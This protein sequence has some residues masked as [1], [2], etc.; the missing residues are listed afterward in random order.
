[1]VSKTYNTLGSSQ[2]QPWHS[3]EIVETPEGK[4]VVFHS[5]IHV[6]KSTKLSFSF[7]VSFSNCDILNDRD[8]VSKFIT[9]YGVDGL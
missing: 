4:E 8:V 6:N 9:M 2:L 3:V 7:G 1:M 5:R